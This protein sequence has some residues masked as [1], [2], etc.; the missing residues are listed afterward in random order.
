MNNN[1]KKYISDSLR[2]KLLMLRKLKQVSQET[3]ASEIN[4]SRQSITNY[5]NRVTLP[6]LE[7]LYLLAE[8]Y[9][10]SC[11]YLLGK[12]NNKNIIK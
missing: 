3:V 9:E 4:S 6:D 8:Y 1:I 12:T 2:G 7:K 5:E 10:V 11:D